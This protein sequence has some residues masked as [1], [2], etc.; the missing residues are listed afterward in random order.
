MAQ[1]INED[2][3]AEPK[4]A[5]VGSWAFWIDNQDTIDQR[6]KAAPYD[7][8]TE[9]VTW[10]DRHSIDAMSLSNADVQTLFNVLDYLGAK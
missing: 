2:E 3:H 8:E 10:S 6:F 9:E 7:P 5:I 4:V 1:T